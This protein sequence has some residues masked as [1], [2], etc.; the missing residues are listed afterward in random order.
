MSEKQVFKNE[1][2]PRVL[3]ISSVPYRNNSPARSLDAFF[4]LWPKEKLAQIFTDSQEP[5]KGHCQKLMQITDS[6]IIKSR[7]GHEIVGKEFNYE[8]MEEEMADRKVKKGKNSHI[9]NLAYHW[10]RRGGATTHLLRK[11][12]WN[13]KYW[14]TTRIRNWIEDFNPDCIFESFSDDYIFL[15]MG[16]TISKEFKIPII[17]KIDDD[18]YLNSCFS[19]NPLYWIYKYSYNKM[20]EISFHKT[21]SAVY[22][23][24]RIRDAY[25]N[26]FGIDGET[27]YLPSTI[28][29]KSQ[30]K[31]D[32]ENVNIVYCGNLRLGRNDTIMKLAKELRNTTSK[33][34]IKVFSNEKDR[35]YYK[36]FNKYSNISFC[37]S[38]PYAQVVAEMR[39]NDIVLVVEDFS[40]INLNKTRYSLSTKVADAL[41]CGSYIMAIGD[42]ECG[43]IDF[44]LRTESAAVCTNEYDISKQYNKLVFDEGYQNR[45]YKKS[46]EV[47][48][49]I[50]DINKNTEIFLKLSNDL[51]KMYKEKQ[52]ASVP[53]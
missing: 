15:D 34:H 37:G 53:N 14:Y 2:F 35:R 7:L 38:I 19:I 5:V 18:Y 24:D 16:E 28:Q 48:L 8:D 49:K 20:V 44:L 4:H 21:C 41:A 47:S 43:A 10:G 33:C 13:R 31:I 27:V 1:S 32:I 17:Y 25:N 45:L 29:R 11:V 50:N 52:Y 6:M 46:K 30:C 40:K 9:I 23:C 26:R 36:G 12:L 22:I 39:N 51:I 42:K 3:I